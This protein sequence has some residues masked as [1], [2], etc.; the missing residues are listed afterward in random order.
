MFNDN[1]SV[2]WTTD[3]VFVACLGDR[4]S[5]QALRGACWETAF[6][7]D[8][9][10]GDGFAVPAFWKLLD[11]RFQLEK[12]AGIRKRAHRRCRSAWATRGAERL[13]GVV[14]DSCE[15]RTAGASK[16]LKR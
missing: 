15:I 8:L 10:R 9:I 11:P 5:N 2:D 14:E 4:L 1:D 3:A 13:L 12:S 7:V 6:V 16:C